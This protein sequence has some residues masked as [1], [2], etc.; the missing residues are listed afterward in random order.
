M[1][2]NKSYL[3]VPILVGATAFSLTLL[4]QAIAS[5]HK[6]SIKEVKQETRELAETLKDYS[7]EQRDKAIKE[8]RKALDDIDKS[9]ASLE[10][11]ID[12]DWDKMNK[13]ARRE[14]RQSL[15][16]L[17]RQ[18]NKVAEWYG[19]MKNSSVEAWEHMKEGFS[20]AYGELYDAWKL[21]TE[22]FKSGN[23]E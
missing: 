13:A 12:R 22:Q 9:I 4:Q 1:K 5:S 14:A 16:E 7:A 15:K 19:S 11:G 3:A 2:I 23:G 10:D 21:S 6:T 8:T 20:D 17:R 18:R